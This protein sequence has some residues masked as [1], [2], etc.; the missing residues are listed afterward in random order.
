[1]GEDYLIDQV[2][3]FYNV[4]ASCWPALAPTALQASQTLYFF[5]QITSDLSPSAMPVSPARSH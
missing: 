4:P 2:T 3:F 5:V 1:M